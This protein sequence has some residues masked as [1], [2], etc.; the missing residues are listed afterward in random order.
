MKAILLA[1]V[2]ICLAFYV[3][4]DGV[5][6]SDWSVVDVKNG[7]GP[8]P[9]DAMAAQVF[10]DGIYTF[11][12]FIENLDPTNFRPNVF[13]NDVWRFNTNSKRWTLRTPTPD[14]AHGSPPP[15]AYS[16]AGRYGDEMIVGFGF[17]YT[18]T[19]DVI[20]AYNDLW[21]YNT[22]SN[23]WRQIRANGTAG[24]PMPRAE[25]SAVVANG[26]IYLYG[27]ANVQFTTLS[28][29]W[30][31]D[32]AADTWTQLT[33]ATKPSKR[34]GS[35]TVLDSAN[36]RMII[37][38]GEKTQ[39]NFT[40]FQLDFVYAGPDGQ[41]AFDF[42]SLTWTQMVPRA[43]IPDRNN[44]NGGVIYNNQLM[45]F[46]GDIGGGSTCTNVIFDQNN[47]KETW[48]Y[49]A[50]INIWLELCPAV[51][52]PNLKR[53]TTVL[54]GNTA[55]MMG[56]FAYDSTTCGPFIFPTDVYAFTFKGC[57]GGKPCDSV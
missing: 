40:T 24:A 44:G 3:Q 20:S 49:D 33:L 51:S 38:G 9:R 13:F 48:I 15:R 4:A 8:L 16:I 35:I 46:G 31:Y 22:V 42:D 36:N 11:G 19:F 12:G 28:D 53:A 52:P 18:A 14:L 39:F 55:Y 32:F 17:N 5:V 29:T 2:F 26:K 27:G 56:G 25:T 57:Y 54:V 47:V 34:Y 45:I 10:D 23:Q 41:W 50:N 37:Y 1:A 6:A 30:V 43:N 21:A 7:P